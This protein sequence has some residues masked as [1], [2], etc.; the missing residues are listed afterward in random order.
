MTADSRHRAAVTDLEHLTGLALAFLKKV[1]LPEIETRPV[2]YALAMFKAV[3]L[4][5]DSVLRLH[6]ASVF[7]SDAGGRIWNPAALAALARMLMEAC[8]NLHYFAGDDVPACERELRCIVADLKRVR[9]RMAAGEHA[10]AEPPAPASEGDVLAQHV[11]RQQAA[12]P[13]ELAYWLGRMEANSSFR[14]LS[15][16]G[17]A[18]WRTGRFGKKMPRHWREGYLLSRPER[19]ENAGIPAKV[20]EQI[21]GLM[22]A[23]AHAGPQAADRIFWFQPFDWVARALQFGVFTELCGM[24]VARAIAEFE[25]VFPDCSAVVTGELR[26]L[27]ECYCTSLSASM[28]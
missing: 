10:A 1:G 11:A 16:P 17:R 2:F 5:A 8:A 24:F 25:R 18:A 23:Y 7:Y 13:G 3:Y 26:V 22:S 9:E 21:Y 14:G 27:V 20:R 12:L 15:E 28:T 19:A 6:P 4:N